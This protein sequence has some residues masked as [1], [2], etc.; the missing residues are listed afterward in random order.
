MYIHWTS[1]QV[2][3]A[4]YNLVHEFPAGKGGN[5]AAA[6]A[7]VIGRSVGTVYNKADPSNEDA[8]FAL[9]EIIALTLASNDY[10]VLHAFAQ[11][12]NH[13]AV[14]LG[15]YRRT[16]DLEL[17][18]CMAKVI[19]ASGVKAGEIRLALEDGRITQD[20]LSRIK[21]CWYNELSA[22]FELIARLEAIADA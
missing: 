13:V 6:A 12:C 15:D 8:S 22:G 21:T 4:V 19:E 2:D 16:S 5:S 1:D 10:R 18:D 20:E 9:R 17:L 11:T 3:R 7:T 14:P